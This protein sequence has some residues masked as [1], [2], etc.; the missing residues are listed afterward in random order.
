MKQLHTEKI[1]LPHKKI[2]ERKIDRPQLDF[3]LEVNRATMCQ[4]RPGEFWRAV[5]PDFTLWLW[6][7]NMTRTAVQNSS[8]STETGRQSNRY[9]E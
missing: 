6:L 4:G 5:I 1:L 3:L 8:E 9:F 7:V 2:S